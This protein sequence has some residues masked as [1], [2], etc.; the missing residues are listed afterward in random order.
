MRMH[1]LAH[2]GRFAGRHQQAD[3]VVSTAFYSLLEP[4]N[5]FTVRG[6][7]ATKEA[8]ILAAAFHTPQYRLAHTVV[9][10]PCLSLHAPFG[11]VLVSPFLVLFLA[12]TFTDV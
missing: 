4:R 1:A 9:L 2:P 6:W 7:S 8:P 11:N 12:K 3:H 10:L 5:T